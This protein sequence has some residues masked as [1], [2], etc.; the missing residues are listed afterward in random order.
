MANSAVAL[1]TYDILPQENGTFGIRVTVPETAPTLV[2]SF[3]TEA[4]AEAWI[5]AH[6][7]RVANP[8]FRKKWRK[9]TA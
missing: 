1:A 5:A 8:P 3:A 6:K 9:R 4:A 2:T 7:E